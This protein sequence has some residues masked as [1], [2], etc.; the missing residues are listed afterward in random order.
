ME[1]GE[2][3]AKIQSVVQDGEW[4]EEDILA[5]VNRG[6]VNIAAGLLL[7]GRYQK[8][9][10]LPAL[11]TIETV[12]TDL[13]SPVVLLPLTFQRNLVQVVNSSNENIPI[14]HSFQTF[15]KSNPELKTGSVRSCA[16]AGKR[17]FYR[18][19]PPSVETLT[20]HFYEKPA[21]M[22]ESDEVDCLPDFLQLS[23]LQSYACT[24]IFEQ[25]EDGIE[26]QK[27]NTQYWKTMF[28]QALLDLEIEIGVDG[29][30][31]HYQNEVLRID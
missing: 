22:F 14:A 28:T 15:L 18:D 23:L 10:P 17:L 6:L 7:P 27:V 12:D 5:I 11:Y 24:D 3:V 26:G 21:E 4:S 25:I 2:I 13:L 31:I 20:L 30:S 8:T 16:V 9:P 29:D 19:I 1:A